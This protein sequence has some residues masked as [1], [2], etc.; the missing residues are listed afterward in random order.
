MSFRVIEGGRAGESRKAFGVGR[1]MFK[2]ANGEYRF[3]KTLLGVVLATCITFVVFQG[4][5]Q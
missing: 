1:A 3:K 5:L 2:Y 4:G